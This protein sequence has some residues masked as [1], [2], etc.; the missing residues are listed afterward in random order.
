[1]AMAIPP[2]S[3]TLKKTQEQQQRFSLRLCHTQQSLVEPNC[4]RT[5]QDVW[6]V[7]HIGLISLPIPSSK[8]PFILMLH[9]LFSSARWNRLIQPWEE[10]IQ[11]MTMADL[12]KLATRDIFLSLFLICSGLLWYISHDLMALREQRWM[13]SRLEQS[14]RDD[15][16]RRAKKKKNLH[17]GSKKG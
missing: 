6:K 7:I 8:K 9:A 13:Q 5:Y 1:M 10:N 11:A 14:G 15:E 4:L 12:S 2:N 17:R 16:P 3:A